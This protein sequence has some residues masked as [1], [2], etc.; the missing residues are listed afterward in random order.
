M[1]LTRQLLLDRLDY[2]EREY[3][4]TQK[5]GWAQI[6]KDLRPPEGNALPRAVAYGQY[7]ELHTLLEMTQPVRQPKRER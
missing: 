6:R 4:F 3:G 2:F 7:E 1:R 5:T